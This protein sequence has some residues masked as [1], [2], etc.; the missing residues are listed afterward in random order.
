M[1][2][3][4]KYTP[5]L[6][7]RV[8][9]RLAAG[10][11]L[12]AIA[13]DPDMPGMRTMTGWAAGVGC[14]P[15]YPP[16]YARATFARAAILSDE[17]LSIADGAAE[18]ADAMAEHAA[19]L[20]AKANGDLSP[21]VADRIYRRVYQEEIQARRLRVDA[22]KWACARMDPARWGDRVQCDIGGQLANP[23]TVKPPD[24]SHLEEGER[25]QLKQLAAR[26]LQGPPD[27]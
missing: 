10:E 19:G 21:K 9:S 11:S 7:D 1:G 24:L 3:P 12:S 14:D 20:V 27:D 15:D 5:E 13:R 25:Q 26:A 22:R 18:A 4:R 6:A 16:R 23:L 8:L 2:R 17:I